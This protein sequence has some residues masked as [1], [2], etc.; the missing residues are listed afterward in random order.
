MKLSISIVLAL[1]SSIITASPV[2]IP[3]RQATPDGVLATINAWLNDISVSL[4][5][6]PSWFLL[7]F[8]FSFLSCST[9]N[10][11]STNYYIVP[12]RE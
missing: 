12:C 11:T 1:A 9:R 10:Y 3:K 4:S 8:L 2:T 6:I 7:L 5:F